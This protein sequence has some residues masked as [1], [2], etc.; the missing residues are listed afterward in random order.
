MQSD[1]DRPPA[2]SQSERVSCS[3]ISSVTPYWRMCDNLD[4]SR[5]EKRASMLPRTSQLVRNPTYNNA[6]VLWQTA[7][8]TALLSLDQDS[9]STR[10]PNFFY[11]AEQKNRRTKKTSLCIL[12]PDWCRF[13]QKWKK[14]C[15]R[16]ILIQ[17][18]AWSK[19]WSIFA[20]NVYDEV[21][22]IADNTSVVMSWFEK[23]LAL[24]DQLDNIS[25]E[26]KEHRVHTKNTAQVI[27]PCSPFPLHVKRLLFNTDA[28]ITRKEHCETVLVSKFRS[29]RC[30]CLSLWCRKAQPSGEKF[31]RSI[32]TNED[33][34][35]EFLHDRS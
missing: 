34:F 11:S 23:L 10:T 5:P 8:Q 19:D 7:S 25:S 24:Q 2:P 32:F 20:E 3:V 12:A 26:N 29:T 4:N 31:C 35:I 33:E 13:N 15:L 30:K 16:E 6:P 28:A 27:N 22:T 18:S 14:S 1:V 9:T 17:V 21:N